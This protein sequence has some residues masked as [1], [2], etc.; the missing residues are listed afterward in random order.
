M[1]IAKASGNTTMNRLMMVIT[2][3]I[4]S[5]FEKY[6]ICDEDLSQKSV[7]D[8]QAIFDAIKNQNSILAQEKMKEHFKFLY[9]YC[10]G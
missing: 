8:H 9:K 5:N 2:P 4:I 3:E 10:N 7:R 1:A 6:H